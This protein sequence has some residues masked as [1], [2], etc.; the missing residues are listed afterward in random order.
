MN[1]HRPRRPRQDGA[2]LR[3]LQLWRRHVELAEMF[4]RT[5]G[6]VPWVPG[7]PCCDPLVLDDFSREALE[8][9]MRNG[10][11]RAHRLRVAVERLDGRFRAVTIERG[12]MVRAAPWWQRREPR[13]WDY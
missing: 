12:D 4:A 7:C 13:D 9:L 11:R 10:G 5:G 8:G 2:A 6:R 3:Y 1:P